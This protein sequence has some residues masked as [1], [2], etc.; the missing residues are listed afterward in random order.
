MRAKIF[1][2]ASASHAS[3]FLPCLLCA[4]PFSYRVRCARGHFPPAFAVRVTIFL[5]R[6]LCTRPFFLPR[7]LCARLFSLCVCCVFSF[8]VCWVRDTLTRLVRVRIFPFRVAMS[9]TTFFSRL[10]YATKF[11][12]YGWP[13]AQWPNTSMNSISMEQHP[14]TVISP[15]GTCHA[16]PLMFNGTTSSNDD[17]LE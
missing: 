4:R 15:S 7:P 16:L 1:P 13:S 6:S 2:S 5:P 12:L 10:V 8:H 11:S 14:L 9:E 3:I 17:V